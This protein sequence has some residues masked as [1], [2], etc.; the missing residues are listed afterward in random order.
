[1]KI[2]LEQI[3]ENEE[4]Q[5][6]VRYCQL[7]PELLQSVGEAL[8]GKSTGDSSA[9]KDEG[10]V[11]AICNGEIFA[12][13]PSEILYIESID[14][15][16]FV[17]CESRVY[18]S[19]QKLKKLEAMLREDSFLRI[20]RTMLVNLNNVRSFFPVLAGQLGATMSNGEKLVIT[21]RYVRDVRTALGLQK[22]A[23]E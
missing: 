23:S 19:A 6:V 3:N 4:E 9:T 5:I 2:I 13:K 18:E 10:R 14:A 20:S 17:Y 8:T 7:R 21:R 11:F 16:T 12:L 1:M 22:E 15:K